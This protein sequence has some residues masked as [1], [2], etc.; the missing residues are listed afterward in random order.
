MNQY[1]SATNAT[2]SQA[3][4]SFDATLPQMQ[5]FDFNRL[6]PIA[7]EQTLAYFRDNPEPR[8]E[9]VGYQNLLEDATGEHDWL[10]GDGME[11]S[12]AG[13][14]QQMHG[15]LDEETDGHLR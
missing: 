9:D 11:E 8:P 12:G 3:G 6:D 15:Q 7:L 5:S 14:V 1:A 10:V 2:S 4:T 13:V